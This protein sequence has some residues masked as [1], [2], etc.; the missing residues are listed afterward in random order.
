MPNAKCYF[1]LLTLL[2]QE[3][4]LSVNFQLQQIAHSQIKV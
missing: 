2:Q 3:Q 1:K 4:R